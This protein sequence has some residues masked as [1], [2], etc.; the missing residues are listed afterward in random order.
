MGKEIIEKL[1]K[2]KTNF[3]LMSGEIYNFEKLAGFDGTSEVRLIEGLKKEIEEYEEAGS[4][5]RRKNKLMDMIVLVMQISRRRGVSLDDAWPW[6]WRKSGK[7]LGE[8]RE[9]YRKKFDGR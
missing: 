2:T 7:Y 5:L 4:E 6:W 1:M 9:R 3:N 8:N